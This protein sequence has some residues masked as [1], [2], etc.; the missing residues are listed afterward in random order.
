MNVNLRHDITHHCLPLT[1]CPP[2]SRRE[3]LTIQ[4]EQWRE[5]EETSKTCF[6]RRGAFNVSGSMYLGHIRLNKWCAN[7]EGSISASYVLHNIGVDAKYIK[8]I[9]YELYLRGHL[10]VIVLRYLRKKSKVMGPSHFLF[11]DPW[12][13]ICSFPAA[14]LA[15]APCTV[16]EVL[17][18]QSYFFSA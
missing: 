15:A 3:D 18:A 8:D 10:Y 6:E 5:I 9:H 13:N 16:Q 12:I 11:V 2:F 1:I 4:S 7:D 14:H 17:E